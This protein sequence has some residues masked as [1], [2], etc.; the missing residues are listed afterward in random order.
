MK[1]DEL[2]AWRKKK[3]ITLSAIVRSTK[4]SSRYLEA[5]ERGRF[6]DL[7]GGAYDISY[8]RQ[9]ARAIQYDADDILDAY[10]RVMM[11]AAAAAP[12]PPETFA[13]RVRERLRALLPRRTSA[14]G[15][16]PSRLRRAAD[17]Y[18]R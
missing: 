16:S 4:I 8:I 7:P 12:A 15:R 2:T 6:R 11:P 3:G 17:A 9:Y 5:I 18:P 13:G 10:R 14:A 1:Q